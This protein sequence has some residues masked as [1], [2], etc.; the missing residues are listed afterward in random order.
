MIISKEQLKNL[1]LEETV[2]VTGCFNLYHPGH[3]YFLKNA[4]AYGENLIVAIAHDEITK[5][6]RK[7]ILNQVQRMYMI[8]SN[9]HVDYVIPEDNEMP[10]DNIKDIVEILCPT[11]WITNTDNPNRKVYK[12]LFKDHLTTIH[13]GKRKNTGI[14]KISTSSII[15]NIITQYNTPKRN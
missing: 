12:D 11:Y 1:D 7:P 15:E 14:F 4:K 3:V 13:I 5:I 9:K 10:P 2:L 8:D 6:K